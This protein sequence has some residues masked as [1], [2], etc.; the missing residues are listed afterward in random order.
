MDS[1]LHKALLKF[2]LPTCQIYL[3]YY[4][5]TLSAITIIMIS[6][7]QFWSAVIS[8]EKYEGDTAGLTPGY[9]PYTMTV[10][11]SKAMQ[12]RKFVGVLIPRLWSSDPG[13]CIYAGDSR[14]G[15]T[16]IGPSA[17]MDSVIEGDYRDYRTRGGL[18][19][20]KFPYSKFQPSVCF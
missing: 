13:Q 1:V 17:P 16:G 2:S 19:G 20:V 10:E 11:Y 6:T 9:S 7:G 15:S 8:A 4:F 3:L 12:S 5:S 18:F 14:G